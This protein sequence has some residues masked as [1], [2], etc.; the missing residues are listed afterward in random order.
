M[1]QTATGK[2]RLT[3]EDISEGIRNDREGSGMLLREYGDA[4]GIT[5]TQVWNLENRPHLA[6]QSRRVI[7]A[8]AKQ[9]F[10][11]EDEI[12]IAAGRPTRAIME[13][14]VSTETRSRG[15]IRVAHM[16]LTNA[17]FYGSTEES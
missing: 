16:A 8:V 10:W 4:L 3:L 12:T 15:A 13:H 17:G 6:L 1:N 9:L 11:D 7:T 14:L 5:K 2:R